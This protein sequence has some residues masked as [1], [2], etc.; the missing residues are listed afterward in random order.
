[1]KKK[2]SRGHP[3]FWLRPDASGRDGEPQ[4]EGSVGFCLIVTEI[5]NSSALN[6]VEVYFSFT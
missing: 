1:M 2:G 4:K 5:Q 6:K 3:D